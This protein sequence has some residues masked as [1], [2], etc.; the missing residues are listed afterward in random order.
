MYDLSLGIE[1]KHLLTLFVPLLFLASSCGY[2]GPMLEVTELKSVLADP[3][4]DI[5][6]I[7]VRP[8]SLFEKGHIEGAI[9]IPVEKLAEQT[10]QIKGM[11][12]KIAVICVC[13]KRSLV[14]VK[15]LAQKGVTAS[16]VVG[17]IKEWE[18]KGYP[19]KKNG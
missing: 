11:S 5:I 4:Q 3:N 1:K 10:E 8:K 16:L 7:D 19:L 14:A 17:G 15:H 2:D 6:V 9:N 12:G 18:A 13:G